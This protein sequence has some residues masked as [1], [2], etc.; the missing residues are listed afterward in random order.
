MLSLLSRLSITAALTGCPVALTLLFGQVITISE[1]LPLRTDYAYS[2]LGWVDGDLLLFRDKGHQYFIQ[3]FDEDMHVRWEREIYLGNRRVDVIG[4]LGQANRFDL[5][6]G[7]REKGDYYIYHRSYAHDVSF[8]DSTTID[9]IHGVFITPQVQLKSSEDEYKIV[10]YREDGGTLL[11]TG[12]DLIRRQQLWKHDIKL[13]GSSL[14]RDFSSL[15][16]SNKGDFYLTMEP[17]RFLQK[18]QSL[19]LF[20][21][22]P[23]VPEAVHKTIELGDYSVYDYY[24]LYDNLNERLILTG[25]YSERFSA[26]AQGFYFVRYLAGE[27]PEFHMLPFNEDLLSE[28]MG[29]EVSASRGLGD[30]NVRDVAL[31]KDGG[32]VI[33]AELNKEFSRR[34][35]MPMR[36][37]NGSYL[38]GGWVDYYYEDLI[39]FAVDANGA[40]RWK[41]V[42]RKRQY[43]QDDEAMYSSYFLFRTPSRL[44]FLF[45]DEI[46]QENTVGGYE[47]TGM[48]HVE[49]KT[50]FN[51]D[52]QRLKL[53]FKDGLQT[54]YNECIVPS[55]RNNRLSLVRIVYT[56]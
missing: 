8:I 51:T 5:I 30:F 45:N 55:E 16:V 47:V 7:M 22:V 32:A 10:L 42:L 27:T 48:G 6:Y 25:L 13:S 4:V 18:V 44:R 24:T 38:R 31:Q 17:D 2:V 37:D 43:S 9:T 54:A 15:E 19:E 40:E 56:D 39:L 3:A 34:S 20:C 33:I 53:R 50:V 12:Y 46:K 29:K 26:K 23:G 11:L 52:Y 28:V 35:S 49:R 21:S 1:E 36:R 41:Q 14:Q